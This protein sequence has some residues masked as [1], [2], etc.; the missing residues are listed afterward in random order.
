MSKAD[1]VLG[2]RTDHESYGMLGFH[3]VTCSGAQPLFGS[4]IKHRDT[5]RLTLKT[6]HMRRSFNEDWY[7]GDNTLFEVEM[8]ATQFADLITSLNQGDGVPVTIRCMR[9]G[10]LHE[11]ED[12]PFVDRGQLHKEEFREHLE[13][14]YAVSNKLI[15][16][17][18]EKFSTKKTFNKTDQ[19]EILDMCRRIRQNIGCNQDFQISQFDRQMERS[20]TEAKGEIEAFFQ[21]KVNQIAQQALVDNPEKLFGDMKSP[22]LLGDDTPRPKLKKAGALKDYIKKE[23]TEQ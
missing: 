19:K 7:Y 23:D 17:L 22:V 21:N 11:C 15:R 8:S 18:E 1:D 14:V 9:E 20:T 4:S 13:D 5:I 2:E 16:E 10:N 3:R 12:P 6:G